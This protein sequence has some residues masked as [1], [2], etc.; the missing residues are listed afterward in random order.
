MSEK[1]KGLMWK[2]PVEIPIGKDENMVIVKVLGFIPLPAALCILPAVDKE[3]KKLDSHKLSAEIIW[4]FLKQCVIDP[5][6]DDEYLKNSDSMALMELFQEINK[7]VQPSEEQ[8][9]EI[10]KTTPTKP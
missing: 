5:V 9:H 10:K 6:I 7:R 2:P 1:K 4:Y 8:L 3:T